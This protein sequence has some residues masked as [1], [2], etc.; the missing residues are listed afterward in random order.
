[1]FSTFF[2]PASL[3]VAEVPAFLFQAA[4]KKLYSFPGQA[5]SADVASLEKFVKAG[6]SGQL[7]EHHRSQPLTL[8]NN[9]RITATAG[10][11]RVQSIVADNFASHVFT[12]KDTLVAVLAPWGVSSP[13]LE[14]AMDQYGKEVVDADVALQ[15]RLNLVKIDGTKNDVQQ[16]EG[17]KISRWVSLV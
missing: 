14:V 11:S 12:D 2:F 17:F 13:R 4:D 1:M 5:F 3:G 7:P 15:N 10:K 9:S 6:L 16:F 8:D